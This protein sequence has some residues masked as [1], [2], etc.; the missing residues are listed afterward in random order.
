[1]PRP[2][3]QL[4]QP[5]EQ[6]VVGELLRETFVVDGFD[7]GRE[8]PRGRTELQQERPEQPGHGPLLVLPGAE[9]VPR[10]VVGLGR[11]TAQGVHDGGAQDGLARP[12]DAVQP[13]EAAGLEQ[14]AR[15]LVGA[16][17][18]L[19]RLADVL[20]P[21][22]L[23]VPVQPEALAELRPGEQMVEEADAFRILCTRVSRR[24]DTEGRD[25]M[26]YRSSIHI[27][28]S[29]HTKVVAVTDIYE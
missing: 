5:P 16:V 24:N 28:D 9:V 29:L 13:Q 6:L 25:R 22:L 14:P 18:P 8:L 20:L 19:A 2:P 15:E 11:E 12:R 1:M 21:R 7:L 10:D 23:V 27:R 26:I 3:H 17:Q 4:L